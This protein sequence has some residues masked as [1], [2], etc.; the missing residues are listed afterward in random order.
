[1]ASRCCPPGRSR[2]RG[3]GSGGYDGDHQW[4]PSATSYLPEGSLLR[5][6]PNFDFEAFV[7][8]LRSFTP[9]AEPLIAVNLGS[10][11]PEEAA[12]WVHYANGVKQYGI[13]YWEVGNEI[14][15]AWEP[16]GAMPRRPSC[17]PHRRHRGS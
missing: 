7:A 12:A 13:R 3:S 4:V 10:G 14:E 15:G 5:R 2:N 16:G 1:M 11:T 9:A 17:H 6:V 8:Y